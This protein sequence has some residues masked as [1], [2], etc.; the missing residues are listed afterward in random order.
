MPFESVTSSVVTVPF[1]LVTS[2]GTSPDTGASGDS[3]ILYAAASGATFVPDLQIGAVHAAAG[4]YRAVLPASATSQVGPLWGYH[5]QGSFAMPIFMLNMRLGSLSTFAFSTDSVG[6]KAQA[7][8]GAT[9][10]VGGIA[11]ATYSGVTVGTNNIA[12]GTYSGATLGVNNIAAGDYSGVT[13]GVKTIA[14]ATY[15]GV[16]VGINN[17]SITMN[18]NIVQI[19]GDAA[20][21]AMLEALMDGGL[22]CQV[23][24]VGSTTTFAVKNFTEATNDHLNGR[25]IT[26]VSGALRY[27]QTAITD[28]VGTGQIVTVD[29]LTE[30]PA[31]DDYLVIH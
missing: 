22:L 6:L 25:L 1:W 3:L 12:P 7:H 16:T 13:V 17:S 26:F 28:Y 31:V 4:Q 27:Q 21:A 23:D 24:N 20:A 5:T 11:P 18:A 30:I 15:S 29:A 19:N 10:G 9:V 2:D 8:S 14:P